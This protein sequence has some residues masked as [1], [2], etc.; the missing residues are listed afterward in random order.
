MKTFQMILINN[1]LTLW[2]ITLNHQ[3]VNN[4]VIWWW[5]KWWIIIHFSL[6]ADIAIPLW[7]RSEKTVPISSNS[8]VILY[9][10]LHPFYG[11]VCSMKILN[12]TN[13][14]NNGNIFVNI[15]FHSASMSC[16]QRIQSIKKWKKKI[17]GWKWLCAQRI[18]VRSNWIR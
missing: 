12:L 7:I 5:L 4:D 11:C 15:D 3:H 13:S 1:K 2:Q 6:H 14:I 9:I 16:E 17:V 8:S 10:R 18:T